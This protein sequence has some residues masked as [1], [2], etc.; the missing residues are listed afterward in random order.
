MNFANM[1]PSI[2]TAIGIFYPRLNINGVTVNG[3]YCIGTWD[4]TTP[5]ASTG[6]ITKDRVVEIYRFPSDE[7]CEENTEGFNP[8]R[9]RSYI[10]ENGER[11]VIP[12]CPIKI[13]QGTADATVDPVMVEEFYKSIRRAGC[14]A[15]LHILDGVAHKVVDTMKKELLLWFERFF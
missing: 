9:S 15:E 7:W 3:H 10:N 14:Y 6:K 4:K 12:P 11:C 8:Y 2:V 5:K 1:F 13:W